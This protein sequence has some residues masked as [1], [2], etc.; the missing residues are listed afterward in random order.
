MSRIFQ[1]VMGS[2]WPTDWTIGAKT[3]KYYHGISWPPKGWIV[4]V[5][6]VNLRRVFSCTLSWTR[7]VILES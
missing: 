2:W 6:T 5:K 7:E 1:I 4:G 3:V